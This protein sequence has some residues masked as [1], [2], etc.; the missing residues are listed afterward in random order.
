MSTITLEQTSVNTIPA[1]EEV[2]QSKAYVKNNGV[3]FATPTQY[4]EPFLS[5]LPSFDA[6]KLDVD[7]SKPV[8]NRNADGT[9]NVAYGRVKVEYDM[10][11]EVIGHQYRLGMIYALDLQNPYIEV[12]LGPRATA[13]MN[14]HIFNAA[15]ISRANILGDITRTYQEAQQYLD[16]AEATVQPFRHMVEMMQHDN[17]SPRALN[18][19]LGASLRRACNNDVGSTAIVY[20]TKA[21]HNPSSRY[22]IP[23]GEDTTRWN[24]FNA[25]TQYITDKVDIADAPRKSLAAA[26]L[27]GVELN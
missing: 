12:Y 26:T 16:E 27:L 5:L 17:L 2:L 20:A 7:Y 14:L 24:V 19:L 6:T 21:L 10:G 1:L 25:I 3:S 8:V 11:L 4:V 9:Q 23:D 13:C 15:H 22:F 18:E